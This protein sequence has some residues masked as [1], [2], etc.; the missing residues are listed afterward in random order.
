MRRFLFTAYA[1]IFYFGAF[2]VAKAAI[3]NYSENQAALS[4]TITAAS[5]EPL[6]YVRYI[7][8]LM[9]AIIT[10]VSVGSLTVNISKYF[11]KNTAGKQAVFAKLIGS[12][13]GMGLILTAI[14]I[15]WA[16]NPELIS[17]DG[18]KFPDF[19]KYY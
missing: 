10:V 7:F 17:L 9:L 6:A 12:L 4:S 16:I 1:I 8:L 14:V 3:L 2:F 11:S 13:V 5:P 19:L 15:L 18:L